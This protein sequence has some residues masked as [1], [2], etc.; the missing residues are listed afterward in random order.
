MKTQKI[1]GTVM[2]LITAMIWGSAF[3]AQSVGM[4]HVG[5]FTFQTVRCLIGSIVLLP[6]IRILDSRKKSVHST[7]TP[8]NP[9]TLW[10]AGILCGILLCTASSLQQKGIMYTTVGKAGFITAMYILLVPLIGCLLGT[11]LTKK[12]C[13][14]IAIAVAGLYLLCM[15]GSF[16]LSKGDTYVILCA[17]FFSL[18]ILAVDHFIDSVDGVKLSCIQ[19][20]ITAFISSVP[21]FLLESPNIHDICL[22]IEPILYTGIL[23]CGVAYTLQILGQ[24][25]TEPTVAS[26]LMSLE[27]VFS[28]LFG[29]LILHEF[30]SSREAAG[31]ILMFTAIILVQLPDRVK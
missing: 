11:K 26:L 4:K 22:A 24:Q 25:Y 15:S 2:L 8:Q 7:H 12:L 9:K 20:L 14:S 5:P 28:L 16:S 6:V 23:S 18:H 21:M 17:V 30:P 31:C 27:S 29:M 13:I 1:R 3:V 10:K 19:F